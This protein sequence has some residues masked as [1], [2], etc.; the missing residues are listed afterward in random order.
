MSPFRALSAQRFH[1]E[2]GSTQLV[3]HGACSLRSSEPE[4]ASL[5]RSPT[6]PQAPRPPSIEERASTHVVG[7]VACISVERARLRGPAL[8]G[9]TNSQAPR[10]PHSIEEQ[11]S[12]PFSL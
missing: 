3:G 4:T 8:A 10:P 11:R 2:L 5:L 6:N 7:H 12:T 9:S 1:P